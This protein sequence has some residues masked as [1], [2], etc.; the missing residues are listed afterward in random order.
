MNIFQY[1]NFLKINIFSIVYE[2]LKS[3]RWE[4][5]LKLK[6]YKVVKSRNIG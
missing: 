5:G 2:F 3:G 4:R 6:V 1:E